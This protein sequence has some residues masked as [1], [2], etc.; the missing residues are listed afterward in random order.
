MIIKTKI[1][2]TTKTQLFIK[3][4]IIFIRANIYCYTKN[5]R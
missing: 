3:I 5:N 4:M 1:L 2:N